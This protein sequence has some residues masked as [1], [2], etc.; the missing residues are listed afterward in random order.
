[1]AA[2]AAGPLTRQARICTA[3]H[4]WS[5]LPAHLALALVGQGVGGHEDDL[6]TGLDDALL[7]AAR[8]HITHT[9]DLVDTGDGQAQR[10]VGLALGHLRG[11][12]GGGG[13]GQERVSFLITGSSSSS[14]SS[15]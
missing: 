14:S 13:C 8:Q 7:H 11:G 1:M 15:K 3:A 5:Q 10:G 12:A 4:R 9:L 6:I 2:H